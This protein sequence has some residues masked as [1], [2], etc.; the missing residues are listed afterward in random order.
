MNLFTHRDLM[1]WLEEFFHTIGTSGYSPNHFGAAR[2]RE[3]ERERVDWNVNIADYWH[4]MGGA[5]SGQAQSMRRNSFD[6][7]GPYA[8]L[9]QQCL[10]D[11]SRYPVSCHRFG[12][13]VNG[14]PTGYH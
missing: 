13:L 11:K 5:C 8:I 3:R 14:Y 10:W 6:T 4:P 9:C 1:Q 12:V 7:L 2:W